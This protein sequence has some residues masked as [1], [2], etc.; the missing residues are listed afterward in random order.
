MSETSAG[1][2]FLTQIAEIVS[3]DSAGRVNDDLLKARDKF[4]SYQS[5]EFLK[6]LIFQYL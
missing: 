2:G 5:P 4:P 3:P 6:N 1:I